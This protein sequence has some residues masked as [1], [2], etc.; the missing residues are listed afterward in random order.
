MFTSIFDSVMKESSMVPIVDAVMKFYSSLG[1]TIPILLV[2]LCI[3]VGVLG[4]RMTD[5]V[6]SVLLFAIGFVASIYWICP[7]L[8]NIL[9]AI[10]GYAIGIAVGIFTAVMSRF[11]YNTVYVGAIG[12]DTYNVCMNAI[13]LVGLTSITKGNIALSLCVAVAVSAVAILLRQYLEIAI[14]SVAGGVGAVFFTHQIFNNSVVLANTGVVIVFVIG[15]L[16]A[17]PM[18]IYQ[19]FTRI[20]F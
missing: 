7:L 16:L 20:R 12:F 1:P 18:F 9:P 3:V 8:K 10:P 6:R 2:A 14:T 5:V 19:Y 11:I 17:V 15:L 4:A 13:F